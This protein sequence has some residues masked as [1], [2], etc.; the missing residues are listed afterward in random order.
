MYA[1]LAYVRSGR[2]MGFNGLW[3]EYWATLGIRL[4]RPGEP[5]PALVLPVAVPVAVAGVG[6][7]G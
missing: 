3:G 6:E 5:M 4:V 1:V 2:R 7:G